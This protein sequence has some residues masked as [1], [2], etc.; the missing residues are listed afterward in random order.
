MTKQW[1]EAIEGRV[2]TKNQMGFMFTEINGASPAFIE[3]CK[4]CHGTVADVGCAYGIAALSVLEQAQCKVLAFDLSPEHLEVLQSSATPQQKQRLTMQAGH[5]PEDFKVADHSLDAIHSSFMFHFLT[6]EQTEI[7]LRKCLQAL[8]PGGK[9]FL[10]IAAVYFKPFTGV[11]ALYEKNIAQG[12]KWPGEISD[13]KNHV[14][15]QDA[16]YVPEFIHVHTVED[17]KKL[18]ENTGFSV[19]KIFYYDM[20]QP[21]WFASGGKGC[22]AAI[23]S[24][25]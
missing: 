16:P 6:G 10:N 22:V 8:K 12:K 21:A 14:P 7:G 2:A 20:T 19:D 11:Q 3:Y 24:K 4:N 18:L 5:F 17:L 15:E 25:S 9:I 1:S 13:F 23:A